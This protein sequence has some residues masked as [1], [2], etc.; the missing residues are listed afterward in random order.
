[1]EPV[2]IAAN[3]REAE[4]V[5]RLLDEEGIEYEVHPEAYMREYTGACMQ[6]LVFE[7]VSGQAGYCRRLFVDRGLKA[8]ILE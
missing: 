4:L 8:G 3:V 5:E 6:G 1:M 2:F 7:V